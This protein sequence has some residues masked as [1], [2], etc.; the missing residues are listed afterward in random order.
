MPIVF[1]YGSLINRSSA[2]KTLGRTLCKNQICC[3]TAHH[4][5]R[6]WT[7]RGCVRLQVKEK[8]IPCDAVFLDLTASQGGQ[9]NGVVI[10][11]S[12][13]E[14]A[15]L[16]IREKG[17]ERCV[18]ELETPEGLVSGYT[19]VI[20]EADKFGHGIILGN[21]KKII[22]EA[23]QELPDS[24]G[25]QFWESTLASDVPVMDGN[26]IFE[27]CEQNGAAGHCL[28]APMSSAQIT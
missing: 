2:E 7:A 20:P 1:G 9:C 19:Y 11:V 8:I 25:A 18:V 17:Y 13:R 16:D 6:S 22:D 26:Y 3:A 14:L 27:D 15:Q 23:L 5:M 10:E 4:F 24:F 12:Q 21:Y 28:E